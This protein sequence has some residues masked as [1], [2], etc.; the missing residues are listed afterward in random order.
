MAHLATL[1]FMSSDD[2]ECA[3]DEEQ[4]SNGDEE[5][6]NRH[7]DNSYDVDKLEEE[8][9]KKTN[10]AVVGN[11]QR[12]AEA[13]VDEEEGS[14]DSDVNEGDSA[15]NSE[16]DDESQAAAETKDGAVKGL[17]A[18]NAHVDLQDDQMKKKNQAT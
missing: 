2:D 11:D 12:N 4:Y 3:E 9:D 7:I 1:A 10:G 18:A 16:E 14:A 15:H 13:E 5:I 17:S 8:E 6:A